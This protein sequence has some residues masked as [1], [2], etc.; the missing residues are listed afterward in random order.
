MPGG[1]GT[2]PRGYAQRSGRGLGYCNGYPTPGYANPS[3]QRGI[4]REYR[5]F[6]EP[7]FNRGYGM[8]YGR[9]FR[10]CFFDYP[11]Y[12]AQYY[13]PNIQNPSFTHL[14]EKG[15]DEYYQ[16]LKSQKEFFE[17]NLKQINQDLEAEQHK[18]D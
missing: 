1:D 2:G 8:G 13:P 5:M 14:P 15:S 6:R 11:Y 4:G 7:R 3:F 18:E 10:G 12:P 16:V 9:R 17:E